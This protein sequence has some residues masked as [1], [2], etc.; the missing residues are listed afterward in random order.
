MCLEAASFRGIERGR[1]S[2]RAGHSFSRSTAGFRLAWVV[3]EYGW[4]WWRQR[5]FTT[6]RHPLS[7]MVAT[8]NAPQKVLL[9]R[10]PGA[11]S[12]D[13]GSPLAHLHTELPTTY[14]GE[15]NLAQSLSALSDP[16]LHLWFGLDYL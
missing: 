3:Y 2:A 16:Q 14:A 1:A 15:R 13:G 4:A 8:K 10:Y 11:M 9:I 12:N 5:P 6:P 7:I